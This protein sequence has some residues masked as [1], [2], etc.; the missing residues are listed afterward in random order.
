[1]V[2]GVCAMTA[3]LAVLVEQMQVALDAIAQAVVFSNAHKQVQWCNAAFEQLVARSHSSIIGHN[4][5]DLLPLA[6]PVSR[7][8]N[9]SSKAIQGEYEI[10]EYK[11]QPP[12]RKAVSVL[13]ISGSGI[14]IE[15]D[16]QRT[17]AALKASEAKF[18]AIVENSNDINVVINPATGKLSY[19]SPK[20]SDLMGYT[21]E[22]MEGKSFAPFL[23]PDDLSK[24]QEVFNRVVTTGEKQLGVE[25]RVRHKNGRWKWHLFNASTLRDE[26]GNLLII[27]SGWDITERKLAEEALRES[28]FKFRTIVENVN[29]MMFSV[30]PDGLVSYISPNVVHVMGYS[31]EEL[32][33]NYMP[34]VHPDDVQNAL[35]VFNQVLTTG[36]KYSDLE[37][38]VQYK[39]GTIA[40]HTS[41]LALSQDAD[42]KK[43]IV[44]VARDISDRKQAEEALKA[45]EAKLNMIL[46]TARGAVSH[47]RNYLVRGWET[48]YHS[49]GSIAVWGYTPEELMAD[50]YLFAS[51][52]HPDDLQEMY[53]NVYDC[54]YEE[55]NYECEYRYFH[56]DG[57]LRWISLTLSSIR[58]EANNCWRTT[59]IS[60]DITDKKRTEEALVASEARLNTILNSTLA[61]IQ[62]VRVQA[63]REWEME[64]C[65]QGSLQIWGYSP[66]AL[67]ADQNLFLSRIVPEDLETTLA[68]GF[69]AIFSEENCEVEYRYNHPDGSL[70][71]I[72]CTLSS[73]RDEA[74]DCWMATIIAT[75]ITEKKL[76]QEALKVSE[77]RLTTILN[78][79]LA[80]IYRVRIY[81]DGEWEFEYC[82]PACLQLWGYAPEALMA[83]KNIFV[84]RMVPEDF[85]ETYKQCLAAVFAGESYEGEYRFNH[86]DGS[87]L[88]IN[89][90]LSPERDEAA[91][92]WMGTVIATDITAR[93]S[94]EAALAE[95]E[96]RYRQIIETAQEGIWEIDADGIT[97]FVNPKMAELLGY[98]VAETI[99]QPIFNF[100]D[101]EYVA[102]ASQ[103]LERR[104][105]GIEEQHDFKFRC[106]DGSDL[107]AIVSC[108]PLQNEKGEFTGALA[109]ITDITERIQAEE[110]LRL[111][112]AR[113]RALYESISFAIV[114]GSPSGI[115]DC[116]SAAE[117]L[118]SCSRADMIG[119]HI[120]L[121]SSPI[122]PNGEDAYTLA[123]QMIKI[124][125]EKGNHTFEWMHRRAD[126]VDFPAE[127]C[128]TAVEV[129]A[130]KFVQAIVQDLSDRKSAEAALAQRASLA[131]FRADVGSALGM[132]DSL[133]MMLNRCAKAAVKHL[134]IDC[135][136]IWTLN[137]AENIFELQANGGSDTRPNPGCDRIPFHKFFPER[138][139][140]L[141]RNNAILKNKAIVNPSWVQREKI[142]AAASYPLM[143]ESEI[144]GM[145]VIFAKS[146]LNESTL[147][148]LDFAAREIAL[149]IKRKQAEAALQRR[150]QIDSLIGS[151][152]RQF[153]DS[154][155]EAAIHFTLQAIANFIN[156]ER[157]CIFAYTENQERY[158]LLYDWCAVGIQVFGNCYA[159]NEASINVCSWLNHQMLNGRVVALSNLD[160]LPPDATETR[161]SFETQLIQSC[162]N[163]PMI[164]GG[165]VVGYIGADSMRFAKTWSQEDINLVR[166]VGEIIAIGRARHQAESALKVAKEAAE[167]ASK[168]KSIFLANMSHELRTPLNAILGFS[169]LMERDPAIT[170]RQR[171]SLGIIN[172]SGEHL[173]ALIDDV[174]EMSKIEAGRIVLNPSPFNLHYLLGTLQEMFQIRTQSKQ[175]FLEFD[176]APD[177]PQFVV[178]DEGK[179][180]QVLINLL[181]NAVKFTGNGGIT[182]RAFVDN[183]PTI[184]PQLFFEI[185][186]TGKGI[187]P[188]E[189]DRLFQPFVQTESGIKSKEGTGLGLTIS[190]QYVQLMGGNINCHSV[191]GEG[192]IFSF[193]LPVTLAKAGE[194]IAQP[195]TKGRVIQLDPNQPLYRILVVDDRQENCQLLLQLLQTVGFET[196]SAANGEEAIAIWQQWHPHLI[197]MDMR[198]PLMDGYEAT[199]QI[200]A[201]QANAVGAGFTDNLT[202][203]T[204]ILSKPAP[205]HTIIIALTASAFEE[206]Q[207]NVLAAGC[208]DFVRKPFREQVIFDKLAQHLGVEYIYEQ[209]TVENY[210]T[211]TN[212]QIEQL[213]GIAEMPSEWIEQVYQAAIAVDGDRI[214]QLIEQ[215]PPNNK[216]L[217]KELSTLVYNFCFDEIM[218]MIEKR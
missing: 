65:S 128:L 211:P 23:H 114:L 37:Y 158:R 130:S 4:L 142:V 161:A 71:W 82:S 15:D 124:A 207:A 176:I 131:A 73:E 126:G 138:S 75:D 198:M 155:A 26:E 38:R 157:L 69:E 139:Q 169:Q 20:V 61:V 94:A 5:L 83:D 135:A 2:A 97:T 44:G 110:A 41:N 103:Y 113:L 125:L 19:I 133:L 106:K 77:N 212:I 160:E 194:I 148:A 183:S 188:A 72:C 120:S 159:G 189:M 91:N 55:R 78:R 147:E 35:D 216:N 177:L 100:M 92:C 181:G 174:L 213:D 178:T 31:P 22:E 42:G 39:D 162:L 167:N 153:I 111:S 1:M 85:T 134:N 204:D 52:I 45:S 67:I 87:L 98:T 54:I 197:W 182:L 190:R 68:Q 119:K 81:A 10:T 50:H 21:P 48:E 170:S 151:I 40:W 115:V 32:I 187:A 172:R 173:L 210:L 195:T 36:E 143:L 86:P 123:N 118:F 56:P 102:I 218:T 60:I 191:L 206:Q 116:N 200:K 76:T 51:R 70:R 29:D 150:A 215:I 101:E 202:T 165:K 53:R 34:A 93:K 27:A 107:W 108:N 132:S 47:Y 129:S 7:D 80:A 140:K 175:L 136:R 109:T 58:D 90:S 193:A 74:A 137:S 214:S 64:Y 43:V 149:G 18:R 168:A 185:E 12:G 17:A 88:W 46:R 84:S 180:R 99:G 11:F 112:E 79:S 146:E 95:S 196:R 89:F 156:A 6:K 141:S 121:F 205:I 201:M 16:C 57:S 164:H 63:N 33:G 24:C 104:R 13:E 166:L 14:E 144:L 145:L 3:N 209:P 25:H 117:Q 184:N 96:E 49:A 186:D 203:P 208:D 66:E 127:V 30:Y 192:S 154:D 179:L 105:Q 59:G 8:L 163:V 171:E 62:R 122:Q 217:A 9:P 199:R 152:S 28:E